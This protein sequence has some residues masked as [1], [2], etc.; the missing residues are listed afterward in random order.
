MFNGFYGNDSYHASRRLTINFGI[1][2]EPYLPW[3]EIHGRTEQFS[4]ANFYAGVRPKEFVNAPAGLLLS[5]DPGVPN[6]GVI[7]SYDDFAQRVG[8][9]YDLT[10][11]GKTSVRGGFGSF[12]DTRT[13]A[14][15]NNRDADITPF[16]PQLNLTPP[17]G[18]FQ[19]SRSG[20]C[21][22]PLP[23]HLS[24]GEHGRVPSPGAGGGLRS[25][26]QV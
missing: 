23:G 22:L 16:S 15:V 9:A 14:V 5:G 2:Y 17:A 18:T 10:G 25:L 3:R 12:Y 8:F 20:L 13:N 6:D 26:D 19:R 11:D 4:P 7:G 21:R 1:R 24:A